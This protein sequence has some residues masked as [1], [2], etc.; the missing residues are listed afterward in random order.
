MKKD[1]YSSKDEEYH[2]VIKLLNELPKERA[3]NNFEYNLNFK[4]KNKNFDINVKEPVC[5]PTSKIMGDST[6]LH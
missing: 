1:H 4:I 3:P 6:F 2:H 5:A